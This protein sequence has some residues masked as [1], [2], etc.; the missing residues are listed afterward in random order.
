MTKTST[1]LAHRLIVALDVSSLDAARRYVG[2]L[3]GLVVFYKIGLELFLAVNADFI[4]E[5]RDRGCRIFLDL[6]LNDIDETVR[7][8]VHLAS[9]L[10][11]EFLTILGN[12]ATA[13]AAVSGRE[14]A[15][16]KIL[17]VPLLSS[18][19][20]QDLQELKL[21]PAHPGGGGRFPTLDAYVLWRAESA[22]AQGCDGVIASGKYVGLLRERFG[23]DLLI[24][25]PG[26]RSSGQETHEHQ[27]SLTPSDAI[28]AGADYLVVGRPV[29]DAPNRREAAQRIL[30]EMESAL[31]SGSTG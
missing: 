5:L 26:V 2:E 14:S 17:T 11:V 9:D 1:P 30:D 21:L 20:E 10:G 25:S 4:K 22:L 18:W 12:Q 7:R 13:K 24:V 8:T 23:P 27:R 29:R 3:E 16:L 28:R 6:K 19:S 31:V 15:S